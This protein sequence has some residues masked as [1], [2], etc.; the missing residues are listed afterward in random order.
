MQVIP[1]DAARL[2]G[3]VCVTR[4]EIRTNPETGEVR[5]NGRGEAVFLVGVAGRRK[6]SRKAWA[7][8]VQTTTEPVGV[9]EGS[10]VALVEFE[11]SP[12]EVEGRH[13]MTY[14]AAA[15]LP[16]DTADKNEKS[17]RGGAAANRSYASGEAPAASGRAAKGGDA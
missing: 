8:E 17:E 15:V 12:W 1:V 11:A 5:P 2:E 10:R 13:G 3:L 16:A 14:R 9:L 6:G 7:I 4:P